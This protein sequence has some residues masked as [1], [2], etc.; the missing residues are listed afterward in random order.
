MVEITGQLEDLADR[1]A[2]LQLARRADPAFVQALSG[3]NELA[4]AH[5]RL[6]ARRT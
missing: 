3:V 1:A 4:L 2:R 5:A 6:L